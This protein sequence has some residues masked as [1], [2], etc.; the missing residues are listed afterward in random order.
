[1]GTPCDKNKSN[2]NNCNFLNKNPRRFQ[3]ITSRDSFIL[4]ACDDQ[5]SY[6]FNINFVSLIAAISHCQ[7]GYQGRPREDR[8]TRRLKEDT[9]CYGRGN[10]TTGSLSIFASFPSRKSP[11]PLSLPLRW[12][13]QTITKMKR[14]VILN[15][16]EMSV[17]WHLF[18][19]YK[20]IGE[21]YVENFIFTWRN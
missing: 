16:M 12:L 21:N 4:F 9:W 3:I 1:M 11:P 5:C 17:K 10:T 7:Q 2:K 6:D 15:E 20:K 19:V 8:W 13:K 14:S 18:W